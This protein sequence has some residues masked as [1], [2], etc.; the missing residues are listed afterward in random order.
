MVVSPSKNQHNLQ[1]NS[2]M[3]CLTNLIATLRFHL[4]YQR[5][6]TNQSVLLLPGGGSAELFWSIIFMKTTVALSVPTNSL[7]GE[8]MEV[9]HTVELAA[10]INDTIVRLLSADKLWSIEHNLNLV[11]VFESL[12]HS[13]SN[14]SRTLANNC[15]ILEVHNSR[16]DG[17]PKFNS[18]IQ[19]FMVEWRSTLLS[20]CTRSRLGI[21]ASPKLR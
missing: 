2:V 13:C 4:D 20:E 6:E 16:L 5:L 17:L 19:N 11:R 21:I 12:S 18:D 1:R 3:R 7:R 8:R 10:M 14:I 9:D 15:G